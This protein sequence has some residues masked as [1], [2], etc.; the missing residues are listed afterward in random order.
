MTD[1][2][3]LVAVVDDESSMCRALSRLLRSAGFKVVTF[4]NGIDFLGSLKAR[5]PDCL[6]LDLHMSPMSGFEVQS[7]LRQA[8]LRIPVVIMT[9]HHTE[10][11]QQR[12]LLAGAVAYLRKP[13]DD[14]VL[15]HEVT[16]AIEKAKP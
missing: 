9:G 14:Q 10:E 5:Q 1:S 8:A 16:A 4:T 3:S 12:A 6:V 15:L 7:R 2:P 11:S 13:V